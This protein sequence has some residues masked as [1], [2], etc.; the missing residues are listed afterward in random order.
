MNGLIYTG[1]DWP[2]LATA[3]ML[4]ERADVSICCDGAAEEAYRYGLPF[5]TLVGDM[6]SIRPDLLEAYQSSHE[7]LEIIQLSVEK[8]WTDTEYAVSHALERG[9]THITFCGGLGKRMDHSLG[10]LQILYGL[11]K[12][13]IPHTLYSKDMFACMINGKYSLKTVPQQTFSLLPF[14]QNCCITIEEAK[15]PLYHQPLP[16]G[17]TLGISNQALGEQVSIQVHEGIVLLIALQSV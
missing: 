3:K 8:D 11:C 1:G 14:A 7:G 5:Q 13:G 2:D 16:L 12:R 15:Y 9:C 17:K 6:D 10:Q 4:S